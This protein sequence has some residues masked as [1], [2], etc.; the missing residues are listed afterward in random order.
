M[1]G[2]LTGCPCCLAPLIYN[3]DQ[4]VVQLNWPASRPWLFLMLTTAYPILEELV[5]RGLIQGWLFRKTSG[6]PLWACI[7]Q[8][9]VLTGIVFTLLHIIAHSPLMAALIM[10]PSLVFGYFRDRYDG[11]LVPSILLH[12]FYNAGYFLIFKPVH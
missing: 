7:S 3:I 1:G 12:C 8:A 11:W 9:N 6:K 10:I 4:P 5:F 2:G